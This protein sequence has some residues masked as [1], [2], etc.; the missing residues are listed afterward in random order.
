MS[1]HFEIATDLGNALSELFILAFFGRPLETSR[2]ERQ[3]IVLIGHNKYP[4]SKS[5]PPDCEFWKS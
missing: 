3:A 4:Q 5:L 1:A 2:D